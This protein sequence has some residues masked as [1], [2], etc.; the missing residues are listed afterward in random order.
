MTEQTNFEENLTQ[1]EIDSLA[2]VLYFDI[3][4]FFNT[5]SGKKLIEKNS[6]EKNSNEKNI[7]NEKSA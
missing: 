6:N 1:E 7:N 4:E 3:K 2:A 5:E